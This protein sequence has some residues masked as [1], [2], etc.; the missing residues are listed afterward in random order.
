MIKCQEKQF[1]LYKFNCIYDNVYFV[2][3]FNCEKLINTD[4]CH[5]LTKRVLVSNKAHSQLPKSLDILH[6]LN[7]SIYSP[8][9]VLTQPS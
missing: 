3:N 4:P 8:T 2:Q 9:I 1:L 7:S 5:F 6:Y